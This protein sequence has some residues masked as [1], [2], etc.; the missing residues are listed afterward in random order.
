MKSALHGIVLCKM[1]AELTVILSDC[2][3]FYQL[4]WNLS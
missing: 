4:K 2:S 3:N 1:P